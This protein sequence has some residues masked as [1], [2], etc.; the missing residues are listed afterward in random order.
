MPDNPPLIGL[1]LLEPDRLAARLE[2]RPALRETLFTAGELAYAEAQ[3]NPILHLTARFCAKEAII[4]ALGIDGWDPLEI[5]VTGGG[6]RTGVHL[7][8]DVA[9]RADDLGVVVNISMTH[10]AAMAGAVAHALPR[11]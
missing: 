5:E 1:D 11:V 8:G 2:R 4:K 10:V 6:E 9:R 7:H 3:P